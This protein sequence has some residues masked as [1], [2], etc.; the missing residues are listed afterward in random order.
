MIKD[1]LKGKPVNEW[2]SYDKMVQCANNYTKADDAMKIVE[3]AIISQAATQ[4]FQ[5]K[6]EKGLS[7][8]KGGWSLAFGYIN[9]KKKIFEMPWQKYLVM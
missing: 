4:N 7:P 2:A 5:L 1:S 8:Y 6:D 9:S 3:S